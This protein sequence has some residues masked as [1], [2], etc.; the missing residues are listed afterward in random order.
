MLASRMTAALATVVLGVS[1]CTSSSSSDDDSD[2][3]VTLL[4]PPGAALFETDPVRPGSDDL[5][6]AYL[7]PGAEV[8]AGQ[9]L[10]ATLTTDLCP[11]AVWSMLGGPGSKF[12]Y[13]D[14][15]VEDAAAGDVVTV[16]VP[17]DFQPGSYQLRLFCFPADFG[18]LVDITVLVAV[19]EPMEVT[20]E[21]R[22]A[23]YCHRISDRFSTDCMTR[24]PT[25]SYGM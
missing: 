25:P 3:G 20:D 15:F 21:N 9:E 23:N 4:P 7:V 24:T 6:I 22:P 8:E 1:A 2:G 13:L 12:S 16:V 18:S 5:L 11:T 14:W 10:A 19:D 17:E